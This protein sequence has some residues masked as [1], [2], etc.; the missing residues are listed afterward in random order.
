MREGGI[1]DLALNKAEYKSL[2]ASTLEYVF[3]PLLSGELESESAKAQKQTQLLL[4]L[5]LHVASCLNLT[6]PATA[7][8]RALKKTL[9]KGLTFLHS[10]ELFAALCSSNRSCTEKQ[11]G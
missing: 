5:D 7:F 6:A 10:E 1:W 4:V 11:G 9:W 2:K 8:K 3:F